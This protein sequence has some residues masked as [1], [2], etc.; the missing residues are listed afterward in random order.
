MFDNMKFNIPFDSPRS[1]LQRDHSPQNILG[2]M[3]DPVIRNGEVIRYKS[4]IGN[5]HL[6]L[7]EDKLTI[8]NS[9]HKYILGDGNNYSNL[10]YS[11]LFQGVIQLGNELGLDLLLA[12]VIS[13]EFGVVITDNNISETLS[14]LGHYKG[15]RPLPMQVN[16]K[17]YGTFYEN[18]THKLKFYD[19]SFEV[20]KRT[21]RII[22]P[23]LMRIEKKYSGS[24]LGSLAAFKNNRIHTL[25]DFLSWISLELLANDLVDSISKIEIRSLPLDI[26]GMTP[27]KIRSW[28]YLQDPYFRNYMK[29]Y[30]LKAFETDRASRNKIIKEYRINGYDHLIEE[31]RNKLDF[32][33]LN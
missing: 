3:F 28:C 1:V 24:H 16:G 10:A 29:K 13:F 26:Q 8:Q 21:G 18:S 4:S 7:R 22:E 33:L 30:H 25:G 14:K 12:K 23:N 9:I 15:N 32:C 6:S 11:Q 17:V 27:R 5:L 20:K 19:K 31:V 2:R